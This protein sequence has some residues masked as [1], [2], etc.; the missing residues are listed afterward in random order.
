MTGRDDGITVIRIPVDRIRVL[1][2]RERDRKKF[3]EV[4]DSIGRVG[5]KQPIKVSRA[6][7][8]NG[9]AKFNLV[10][11]QGRLEAFKA[12]GQKEIPA[13]VTDLSEQDS[14]ILSLVENVARR[15]ARP[16]EL[17]RAI[18]KLVEQGYSDAEIGRKIGYS[19]QHVAKIR[20][21]LKAGEER[22]LIAVETGKMPLK[23]AMVIATENDDE[24]KRLLKE[25][26]EKFGL[27]VK[28][29]AELRRQ[30]DR[31]LKYG[32]ENRPVRSDRSRKPISTAT[33]VRNLNNEA[34]RKKQLIKKADLTAAQLRF[35]V[36][37][38]GMLLDDEHFVTLLR[39]EELQTM[40]APLARL[41]G[42]LGNA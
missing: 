14:L 6:R 23:A 34:E 17:F 16:G 37:G 19:A 27:T 28:Q 31:R 30:V 24:I 7:G 20:R 42:E 36:D 39:A 2:P 3:Q 40:P 8:S 9:E 21:L 15:Q 26:R 4:V 22:L 33:Q 35:F 18:G 13:I 25:A 32:K 5:L 10:Y 1:N 12:L 11:G 41:I 29:L 38:L